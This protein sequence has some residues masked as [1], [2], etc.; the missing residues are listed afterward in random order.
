MTEIL[1]DLL[2]PENRA[3]LFVLIGIFAVIAAYLIYLIRGGWLVLKLPWFSLKKTKEKEGKNARAGY[4]KLL[5][6]K[7]T[8]LSDR[9]RSAKPSYQR[10]VKRLKEADRQVPVFD[11]A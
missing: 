8:H 9:L 11:E 5:Y 2:K 6:V 4:R 10:T 1:R 7:V 3:V